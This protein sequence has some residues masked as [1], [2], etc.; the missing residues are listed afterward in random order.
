MQDLKAGRVLADEIDLRKF[1][2]DQSIYEITPLAVVFPSDLEGLQKVINFAK[3]EG[4][5]LTPRGGG[6]GTAGGALGEGIIVA[7]AS[8]GFFGKIGAFSRSGESIFVQ[9]GAGVFHGDFQRCLRE[10]GLFLPADVSSA[11]I[12]QIGGNIATK[13]SGPHAL[14]FGSID[15]FTEHVEFFS[16]RGELVNTA[17]PTTIPERFRDGLQDMANRLL[18]NASAWNFLKGREGMKVASGYNLFPFIRKLPPGELLAQLLVGSNGTLGLVTAATLRVVPYDPGRETMLLFFDDLQEAGRA[19]VAIRDAGVAAIEIMNRKTVRILQKRTAAGEVLTH[20]AHVL[21]IEFSGPG[22]HDAVAE[23][24]GIL[25]AGGY[26]TLAEPVIGAVEDEIEKLWEARRQ[27]LW[28]IRNP[29]PHLKALS[30][31]NDVGVPL[32][33]LADFIVDVEKVFENHG[34]ETMIYGHGG[35]GNLHLRPLFDVT[36]SDLPEAI[37]RLTDDVYEVVFRF[38]GTVSAEHGTGRLRIAYLQREWGDALYGFMQEL[39]ALF[40]PQ[41]LLNPGVMFGEQGFSRYLRKDFSA[42]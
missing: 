25:K 16:A 19:I 1:S 40:D 11:G 21:F 8:D 9:A 13:A 5:P 15:R 27:I 14:R 34:L 28:L 17:D 6:S 33:H 18:K 4:F 12:S 38:G 7:L 42:P 3:E 20:D 30:V 41:G 24:R 23:V 29:A 36:R 32:R 39:K 35:S 26:R 31:V 37:K 10:R 22:G 2:R